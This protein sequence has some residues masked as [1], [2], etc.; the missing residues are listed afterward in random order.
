MASRSILGSC[1]GKG[2]EQARESRSVSRDPR[3]SLLQA[4]PPYSFPDFR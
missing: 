3:W 1:S 4:L 2:V